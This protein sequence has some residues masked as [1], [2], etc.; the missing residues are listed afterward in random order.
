MLLKA[1]DDE[2]A[3]QEY[4]VVD[5]VLATGHKNRQSL[6][7]YRKKFA[8]RLKVLREQQKA[9]KRNASSP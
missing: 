6:L 7:N 1:T 9:K 2:F 5:E 3:R 8:P 4:H